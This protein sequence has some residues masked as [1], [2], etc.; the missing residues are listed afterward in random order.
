MQARF[1]VAFA[2]LVIGAAFMCAVKAQSKPAASNSEG[3]ATHGTVNIFLGNKNGLVVV[4]DSRL[5]NGVSNQGDGQKLFRV[6]DKTICTIAGWFSDSGPDV[7]PDATVEPS[8]PS[9]LAVPEIIQSYITYLSD[10]GEAHKSIEQKMQ[11]LS[12]ALRGG[13]IGVNLVDQ[14]AGLKR[15]PT[16]SQITVAGYENG[17]LELLQAEVVP[18][19]RDGVIE[20]YTIY[21]DHP[22]IEIGESSGFVP[23]FRGTP[24]TAERILNG[25]YPSVNNDPILRDFRASLA[26][27]KGSSL[28]LEDL[29]FIAKRIEVA[30]AKDYPDTVGG[31]RQIAE[32]SDG[33]VSSFDQPVAIE[34][35][36]YWAVRLELSGGTVKGARSAVV[37]KPPFV[38]LAQRIGAREL[39]AQALDGIFFYK[40]MFTKCGFTYKGDPNSIFDKSN[41]VVDSTLTLLPGANPNSNFVKQ[42]KLDFPA[43]IIIDQTRSPKGP[44]NVIA[45]AH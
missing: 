42:I 34:Y 36:P 37:S 45:P 38:V 40:S 22:A 21:R 3:D 39:S 28:S 6:D 16:E 17:R 26:S 14:A 18:V 35:P 7:Q 9:Y 23:V 5:S 11:L 41:T 32:L 2:L 15:Q 33:E 12:A 10:V 31:Q 27:D 44:V 1:R 25:T 4:T 43:L 13:L 30:T 19:V 29:K 20:D 8:F 24:G